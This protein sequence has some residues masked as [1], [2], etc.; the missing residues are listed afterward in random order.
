MTE[1]RP[2]G[3]FEK[4]MDSDYDFPYTHWENKKDCDL[5]KLIDVGNEVT[6]G[7]FGGFVIC[8]CVTDVNLNQSIIKL[9]TG[10]QILRPGD[11]TALC[12][13]RV[14]SICCKNIEWLF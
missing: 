1:E 7:T 6:L 3:K 8:G 2:F 4:K 14:L 12:T 5:C 13:D 9:A 11:C 10:A